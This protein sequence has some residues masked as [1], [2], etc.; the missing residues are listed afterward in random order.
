VKYFIPIALFLVA[1]QP[2]ETCKLE[3]LMFQKP[4]VDSLYTMTFDE[5]WNAG[6]GLDSLLCEKRVY[7]L[8]VD[9]FWTINPYMPYCEYYGIGCGFRNRDFL[10]VEVTNQGL[11]VKDTVYAKD[12]LLTLY[13][14]FY[15]NNGKNPKWSRSPQ[16]A[17]I[18]VGWDSTAQKQDVKEVL[19]TVFKFY[20]GIRKTLIPA[21]SNACDYY[22]NH[23]A[24]IMKKYPAKFWISRDVEIELPPPEP[25]LFLE[26]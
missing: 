19:S 10:E 26:D 17:W 16:K 23:E 15:F 12:S 20:I 7:G 13:S 1:C 24:E 5:F 18:G 11:R 25:I 21:D 6:E 4:N 2:Q 8:N 22:K 9:G 14:A 3:D